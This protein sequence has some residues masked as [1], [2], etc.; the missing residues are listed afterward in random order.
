MLMG[1]AL[2]HDVMVHFRSVPMHL[3]GLVMSPFSGRAV[4]EGSEYDL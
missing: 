1:S 4:R 2:Y 3:W